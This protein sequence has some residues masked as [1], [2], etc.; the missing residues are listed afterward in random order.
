MPDEAHSLPITMD[1][2][3]AAAVRLAGVALRTPVMTSRTANDI[4]GGSLFFKC[5]NFQRGGAFKFRGAYNHIASL[6]PQERRRGIVATSSGNHAQGVALACRL[7]GVPPTILMPADAPANK[8]AA[9]RGY[10]ATVVTYDRQAVYPEAFVQE[11]AR[12]HGLHWVPAYDDPLIMAGQGTTALELIEEA[13]QLD[14]LVVPAGGGGLMS[15]CATAAKALLPGIRVIGV[16][17]EGAD[18]WVRSLARGERVMIDPPDTIA[19][20]IRTRQPGARP[21]AVAREL[22]D[23][24]VTVSDEEVRSAVRFLL[25][26]MKLLAEPTGAVAPAAALSGRLGPLAGQ[27]VGIVIS[28]GNVDPEVLCAILGDGGE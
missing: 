7:L 26:R 5:E 25:W 18:D 21:F 19:D 24:V 11:Y 28:G 15:G 22:V 1:D 20:G 14:L 10:G 9:T 4:A 27:R 23:A 17:T 13:G 12:E 16:E 2:I 6:A 8:V 3:Q